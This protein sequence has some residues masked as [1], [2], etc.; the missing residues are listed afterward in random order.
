MILIQSSCVCHPSQEVQL[1]LQQETIVMCR[2][3]WRV[4]CPK[5]VFN[6]AFYSQLC[7]GST[8]Y[9]LYIPKWPVISETDRFSRE[10]ETFPCSKSTLFRNQIMSELFDLV[11]AY[12]ITSLFHSLSS[13]WWQ[14]RDSQFQEFEPRNKNLQKEADFFFLSHPFAQR[15]QESIRYKVVFCPKAVWS[16]FLFLFF[17][18]LC[19]L[20]T[21]GTLGVGPTRG[22]PYDN[23]INQDS[24]TRRLQLTTR[25]L[26]Q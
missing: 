3:I 15:W 23:L 11:W 5:A 17:I 14:S 12:Y 20:F 10:T 24:T 7:D 13:T 16:Y 1:T 9:D 18:L 21:A 19:G 26:L 22:W 8:F 2:N 4:F 6:L 25:K